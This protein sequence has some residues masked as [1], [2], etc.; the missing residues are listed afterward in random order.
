MGVH[1]GGWYYMGGMEGELL[2]SRDRE[3]YG[4]FCRGH[5]EVTGFGVKSINR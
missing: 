3:T 2:A 4:S 1:G 5:Q